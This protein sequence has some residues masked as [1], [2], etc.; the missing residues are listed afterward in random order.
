MK[1]KLPN[2]DWITFVSLN[3]ETTA[4]EFQQYLLS[5]GID[6]PLNRISVSADR[7][8]TEATAIVSF[9]RSDILSLVQRAISKSAVRGR[10]P[11]LFVPAHL[12]AR[13]LGLAREPS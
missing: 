1:P 11:K 5:A 13:D 7:S 12:L 2:G 4:V 8:K 6:I 10:K 3:R 9:Q